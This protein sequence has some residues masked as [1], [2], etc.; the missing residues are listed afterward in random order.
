MTVALRR[1]DLRGLARHRRGAWRHDNRGIMIAVDD[2]AIDV[3]LVVGAIT[4]E[5]GHWPFYLVEQGTDPG[6]IIDIVCGQFRGDDL[7]GIGVHADMQLPPGSACLGA[8]FLDQP[9]SR[10]A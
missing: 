8:V 1:L 3:V 9:F 5:R 2:G 7:A 4:G 10:P 6:R